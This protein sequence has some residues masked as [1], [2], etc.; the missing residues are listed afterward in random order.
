[1][2]KRSNDDKWVYMQT[3]ERRRDEKKKTINEQV[4]ETSI[5]LNKIFKSSIP[6]FVENLCFVTDDK[7]FTVRDFVCKKI[8]EQLLEIREKKVVHELIVSLDEKKKKKR[9]HTKKKKEKKDDEEDAKENIKENDSNNDEEKAKS[10]E[11]ETITFTDKAS[12]KEEETIEMSQNTEPST[13]VEKEET[14][15][16]KASKSKKKKNKGIFPI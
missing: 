1:M 3:F 7:A 8:Y 4:N 11:E 12:Q 13:T 9:K 5:E 6:L 16:I 14:N 2:I 10:V 15:T